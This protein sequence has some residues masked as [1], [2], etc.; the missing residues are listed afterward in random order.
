MT[1]C[2]GKYIDREQKKIHNRSLGHRTGEMYAME[3][4]YKAI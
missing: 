3:K 2:S 4:N 1:T